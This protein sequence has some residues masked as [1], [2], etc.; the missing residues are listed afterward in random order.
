MKGLEVRQRRARRAADHATPPPSLADLCRLAHARRS[1]RSEIGPDMVPTSAR[2][3]P[4]LA[5]YRLTA[6][7]PC[8]FVGKGPLG[9]ARSWWGFAVPATTLAGRRNRT[10]SAPVRRD[11]LHR[12][13][14]VRSWPRRRRAVAAPR[15]LQR[16]CSLIVIQYLGRR[17]QRR[18]RPRRRST[19]SRSPA[20]ACSDATARRC[21]PVIPRRVRVPR[22]QRDVFG[23]RASSTTEVHGLRSGS[24]PHR[25]R[26]PATRTQRTRTSR[27]SPAR[28]RAGLRSRSAS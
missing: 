4:A 14:Q 10:T 24:D 3:A 26:Q 2:P 11:V 1:T 27:R 8:C 7:F 13:G 19:T 17:G 23:H 22:W 20:A 21:A 15:P 18:G 28:G 16:R 6:P 9:R 12:R 5:A 25:A